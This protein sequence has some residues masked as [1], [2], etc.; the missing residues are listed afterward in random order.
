MSYGIR[1]T[2]IGSWQT[3]LLSCWFIDMLDFVGCCGKHNLASI[4]W[5][6]G[7]IWCNLEN[8]YRRPFHKPAWPVQPI[9]PFLMLIF[10]QPLCSCSDTIPSWARN[11]WHALL[12]CRSGHPA[13][14]FQVSSTVINKWDRQLFWPVGGRWA[15][16][17]L[18]LSLQ[19]LG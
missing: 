4:M 1:K 16:G 8:K 18:S 6:N 3:T 10:L 17:P 19:L 14:P 11:E 9:T 7:P 15:A 13:I 2:G 5:N 12:C